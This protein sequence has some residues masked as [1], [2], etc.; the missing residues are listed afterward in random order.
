MY[1][2][3]RT[4]FGYY[5]VIEGTFD[6]AEAA[7]FKDEIRARLTGSI[8]SF[9]AIVDIRKLVPPHSLGQS[10][11]CESI[12]VAFGGGMQR[13]A[14]IYNSPIIRDMLKQFAFLLGRNPVGRYIDASKV[15][16]PD[17]VA[18]D[19]IEHG[20]E[21]PQTMTQKISIITGQ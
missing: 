6:D 20:V 8:E 16:N 10:H 19:Y 12:D 13:V 5:V 14:A 3:Q 1:S 11:L 18:L 21:P 17:Q 9:S 4:S 15:D 7:Q 2:I